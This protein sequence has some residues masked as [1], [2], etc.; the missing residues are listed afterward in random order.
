MPFRARRVL[1]PH[2]VAASQDDMPMERALTES[3]RGEPRSVVVHVGLGGQGSPNLL[4]L[5][6]RLGSRTFA[7]ARGAELVCHRGDLLDRD[8]KPCRD[9]SDAERCRWCCAGSW[10][11]KPRAHDLR[12]RV[13]LFVAGLHTCEAITVPSD[14]DAAFVTGLGVA[15]SRISVG[16]SVEDLLGHVMASVD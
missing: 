15:A 5:G 6:D 16:G 1:Q 4:W 11:S 9:W 8:R 14:D 10:W 7:C 13:D 12:N 3:L 2:E